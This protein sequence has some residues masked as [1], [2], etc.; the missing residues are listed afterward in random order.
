MQSII[1][2]SIIKVKKKEKNNLFYF[3]GDMNGDCIVNLNG[4]AI[5][6]KKE[7]IRLLKKA[8]ESILDI[9]EIII[10]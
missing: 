9:K 4:Y 6:P 1:E 10:K 5:I 8:K 2:N 3:V 7:Y